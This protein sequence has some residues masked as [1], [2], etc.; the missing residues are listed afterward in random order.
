MLVLSRKKSQTIHIGNDIE[1]VLLKVSGRN[2][3]IGIKAPAGV[4]ILR[5]E[6]TRRCE[7][8]KEEPHAA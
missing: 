3:S 4:T 6:L 1:I 8:D 2:V 7:H 5:G